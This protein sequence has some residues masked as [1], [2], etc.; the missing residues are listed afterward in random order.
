MTKKI[1]KHSANASVQ[2]PSDYCFAFL[3]PSLLALIETVKNIFDNS[4][5]KSIKLCTIII[6]VL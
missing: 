1:L 2:T 4:K 5:R 3:P 6:V